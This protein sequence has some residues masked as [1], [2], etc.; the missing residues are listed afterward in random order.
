MLYADDICI[1]S[2]SSSGLQQLLNICNDNCD[3]HDLTL[4]TKKSMCM[5]FSIDINK[6]CGLPVIYLGNYVFQF[7]KEVKYLGVMIHSSIKT[8]IDAARLTRKFYMQ[9]NLL[10]R[11]FRLFSDYFKCAVFQSYCTI[12]YEPADLTVHPP[13][14]IA[15]EGGFIFLYRCLVFIKKCPQR[16]A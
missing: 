16:K 5:Y 9:A 3:L 7:G 8:I 2:L 6:H 1:V 12:G 13:P 4:N 10:I 15:A 11:N 14:P